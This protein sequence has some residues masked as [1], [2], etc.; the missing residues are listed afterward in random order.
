MLIYRVKSNKENSTFYCGASEYVE[1]R[2]HKWKHKIAT[3]NSVGHHKKPGFACSHTSNVLA[4]LLL[5]I[6]QANHT[7]TYTIITFQGQRLQFF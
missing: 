3:N 2:Y 1:D 7:I 6:S 4:T 5:K